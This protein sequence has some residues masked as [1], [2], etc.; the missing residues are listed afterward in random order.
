MTF[1]KRPNSTKLS[2]ISFFEKSQKKAKSH[3]YFRLTLV[4][5][6]LGFYKC[7]MSIG[8]KIQMI[9]NNIGCKLA[10]NVYNFYIK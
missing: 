9:Q 6:S 5:L 2:Q 4:R 10:A 3:Q 8:E 1:K 7:S